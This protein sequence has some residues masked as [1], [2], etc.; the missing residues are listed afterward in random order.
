MGSYV[1]SHGAN[2]CLLIESEKCPRAVLP[3]YVNPL[4]DAIVDI[5]TGEVLT[6][7]VSLG[8]TPYLFS[9][10]RRTWPDKYSKAFP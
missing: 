8:S 9:P 2:L 6:A 7:N 4:G 10:R 3:C 1:V 5:G